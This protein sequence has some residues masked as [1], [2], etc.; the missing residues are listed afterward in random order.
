MLP[1]ARQRAAIVVVSGLLAVVAGACSSEGD[2]TTATTIDPASTTTEV[3]PA[4]T[5]VLDLTT[6]T[7]PGP[8]RVNV[9]TTPLGP[10]LVDGDGLTLY[11]FT[12]DTAA[13]IGCVGICAQSWPPFLATSVVP[14]PGL[15]ATAFTATPRSD[16]PAG[17]TGGQVTVAGHPLYRF[18]GDAHAGET[19]GQGFNGTWFVVRPDGTLLDPA[20]ATTTT[21]TAP[22]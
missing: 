5:A 2:A 16:A 14:G 12:G 22:D 18:T 15:E 21:T 20:T 17:M 9:G 8:G 13:A 1:S 6:T 10:I 7:L 19:I 3:P 4:P 11:A